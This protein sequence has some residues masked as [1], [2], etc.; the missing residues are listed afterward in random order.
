MKYETIKVA[1]E[2]ATSIITIDRPEAL[3]AISSTVI[4]ELGNAV[5]EIE[6][7]D[8][9]R[10]VI[11]TGAGKAF[12]A[13]ADIAEMVDLGAADAERF[14]AYGSAVM[15]RMERSSKV[16][17]AAANGFALG[18]GCELA[19]ACDF[20]VASAKAKFGQP[21]AK[22]GVIPGF[23]GTQRLL[24]RVGVGQTKRLVL[25]G[26]IIRADEALQ[27]GLVDEVVAPEE[28]LP[29]CQE[30]AGLIAVNGPLA[31]DEGKSVIRNGMDCGLEQA[32]A[33]ER[34]GFA[35]LFATDDQHEGMAAFLAKRPANF[36]SK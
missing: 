15:E 31:V 35:T 30:L 4:R 33:L 24:R 7:D 17:I 21:E 3:N 13:G 36:T 16:Y 27:M 19:L 29:R 18:G 22:L 34:K 28:L 23:G 32:L 6:L 10:T 25:T 1:T 9:I 12:V 26:I 8:A 14:S 11:I 20:I 2:G 5:S